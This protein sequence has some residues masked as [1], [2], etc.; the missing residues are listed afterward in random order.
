M[1]NFS[2]GSE[3]QI[4]AQRLFTASGLQIELPNFL[5][6]NFLNIICNVES[7]VSTVENSCYVQ[8]REAVCA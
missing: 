5:N 1:P 6:A 3:D 4:Q 7:E 2:V 8:H